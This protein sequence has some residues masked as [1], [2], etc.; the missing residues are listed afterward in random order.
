MNDATILLSRIFLP[1]HLVAYILL[2]YTLPVAAFK[3]Q[4]GFDPEKVQSPDPVMLLIERYRDG[5]LSISLLLAVA[6][7]LS[8]RLLDFLP[9]I[10]FLG[11]QAFNIAVT[12]LLAYLLFGGLVVGTPSFGG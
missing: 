1:A 3:R 9:A 4:H 6:H 12:L 5:I 11:G 8:P 2:T 7:A 10:A